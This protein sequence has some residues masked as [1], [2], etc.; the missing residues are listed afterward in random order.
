VSSWAPSSGAIEPPAAP[1][2]HLAVTEE[3]VLRRDGVR[4]I[5]AHHVPF[6]QG[7][8]DRVGRIGLLVGQS[9]LDALALPLLGH[10]RPESVHATRA[11][12]WRVALV[13][14]IID[15]AVIEGVLRLQLVLVIEAVAAQR[16]RPRALM[17]GH[18][19]TLILDSLKCRWKASRQGSHCS[20]AERGTCA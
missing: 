12:W 16:L 1:I 2:A 15:T 7:V 13:K 6:G 10:R 4:V 14:E 5:A 9:L 20:G 8:L 18:A 19:P 17:V 3:V 11:F